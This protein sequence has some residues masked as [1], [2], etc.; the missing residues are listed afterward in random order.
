[1]SK[2]EKFDRIRFFSFVE[3]ELMALLEYQDNEVF[4]G[5]ACW[6]SCLV[7]DSSDGKD[8]KKG[9]CNFDDWA[10]GIDFSYAFSSKEE[11]EKETF[12]RYQ[13]DFYSIRDDYEKGLKS[14]DDVKHTSYYKLM[15]QLLT[16]LNESSVFNDIKTTKD[17]DVYVVIHEKKLIPNMVNIQI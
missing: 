15:I 13:N 1:M 12:L 16:Y 14:I 3:A 9:V 8:R 4:S 5:I 7:L 2:I 6:F 11:N 17:F 10:H